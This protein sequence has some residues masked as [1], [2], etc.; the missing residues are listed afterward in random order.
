MARRN[1]LGV[2]LL[3]AATTKLTK[4]SRNWFHWYDR[5]ERRKQ[6][7]DINVHVYSDPPFNW[8]H[9]NC[10]A[11]NTPLF[12]NYARF[13]HGGLCS[14][15]ATLLF[16]TPKTTSQYNIP[17][18]TPNIDD[19]WFAKQANQLLKQG[20]S[21]E[22]HNASIFIVPALLNMC[23][24]LYLGFLKNSFWKTTTPRSGTRL[25]HTNS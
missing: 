14:K 24:S 18:F 9:K 23:V 7:S 17:D 8:L 19:Y 6:L 4:S 2:C 20:R 25:P 21:V 3:L 10:T 5:L 12:S 13:K 15:R 22:P 16:S 1:I 11:M